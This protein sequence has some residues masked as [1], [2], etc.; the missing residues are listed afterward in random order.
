MEPQGL[1]QKYRPRT[2]TEV[3]GQKDAVKVISGFKDKIPKVIA[4]FGAS[5]SGKT[6]LARVI[7]RMLGTEPDYSM[8]YQ[9]INCASLE[10]PLDACRDLA[11]KSAQMPMGGKFRVWVL[12]EFQSLSRAGF[13]QQALLKVLEDPPAPAY[14]ILCSTDP[15]KILPAIRS[16]CRVIE[17]SP[18][19]P[20]DITTILQRVVKAEG[21]SL[22]PDAELLDAIVE[23]S[24]GNARTAITELEKVIGISDPAERVAAVGLTGARKIARDLIGALIYFKNRS[25][26]DWSAVSSIIEAVRR[27][28]D[29]EGVRQMLLAVAVD[30]ML[31]KAGSIAQRCYKVIRCLDMPLYDRNSG[32]ALLTA[33][34]WEITNAK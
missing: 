34:C 11:V 32:W 18:L 6:T 5:G 9:E 21:V 22:A 30:G 20:K 8:D 17:V 28:E 12:D 26:P 4:L 15:Q 25:A 24:A 29:P 23:S 2:L 13:A 10:S 19:K 14:F 1:Y 33:A 7:A 31:N 16:R 3:V 27:E